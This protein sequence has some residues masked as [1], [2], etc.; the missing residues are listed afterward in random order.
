MKIECKVI[1]VSRGSNRARSGRRTTLVNI[2]ESGLLVDP[3]V[4]SYLFFL[5]GRV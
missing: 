4:I 5:L 1:T 2:R 3:R